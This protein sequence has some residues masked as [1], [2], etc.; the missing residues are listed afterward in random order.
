MNLD[1][2]HILLIDDDKDIHDAVEAILKPRGYRVTC[3]WTGPSGLAEL[4]RNRPD[5]LLLDIMLA[6]PTEGL[7]IAREIRNDPEICDVPIIMISAIGK[8]PS[9]DFKL[10]DA[11][12]ADLFL[13]KPI[14]GKVLLQ[15]VED[16]LESRARA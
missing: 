5:L 8:N 2:K 12:H 9:V 11:H 13:E 6:T 16:T 1:G 7:D 14:D 10:S 15:A 3:C 4:R